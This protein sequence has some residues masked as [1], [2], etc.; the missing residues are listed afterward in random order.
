VA[1]VVLLVGCASADDTVVAGDTVVPGDTASGTVTSRPVPLPDAGVLDDVFD[2]VTVQVTDAEGG[3]R[4][5][6]MWSA[7]TES[8][9]ARG[10][11][12]VEHLEG[13]DGMVFVYDRPTSSSFWMKD[14]LIPLSIAYVDADGDWV[15]AQDMEPC[16]PG[17]DCPLYPPPGE[18][19]LAIEVPQGGL[20]DLGLVPGSRV[21]LGDACVVTPR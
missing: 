21:E 11:M 2:T 14:T 4:T 7:D 13:A 10:L 3:R 9:R 5:P 1:L 20:V 12:Q 17:T 8:E 16:P 19:V 15:G 18:F 6:C